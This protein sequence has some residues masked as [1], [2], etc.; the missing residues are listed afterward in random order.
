MKQYILSIFKA[1]IMIFIAI[2]ISFVNFGLMMLLNQFGAAFWFDDGTVTIICS[3]FIVL[4]I[5]LEIS[6]KK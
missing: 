3:L 2:I 1:Y 5:Y 6:K 4:F